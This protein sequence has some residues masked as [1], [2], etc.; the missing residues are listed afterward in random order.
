MM[1]AMMSPQNV[2]RNARAFLTTVIDLVM[3][4]H[5]RSARL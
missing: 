1:G 4:N 2:D 3:V 5:E